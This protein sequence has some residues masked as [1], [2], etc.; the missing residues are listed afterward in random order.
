MPYF[1]CQICDMWESTELR[2][3]FRLR[4]KSFCGDCWNKLLDKYPHLE[5]YDF[6]DSGSTWQLKEP[7]KKMPRIAWK[8]IISNMKEQM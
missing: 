6:E 5:D 2:D 8:T 1:G 4:G 7:E 3:C